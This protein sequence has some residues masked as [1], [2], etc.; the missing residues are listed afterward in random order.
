MIHNANVVYRFWGYVCLVI[1]KEPSAILTLR[2]DPHTYVWNQITPFRATQIFP[3]VHTFQPHSQHVYSETPPQCCTIPHCSTHTHDSSR[4]QA[5]GSQNTHTWIFSALWG[6]ERPPRTS[7][8]GWARVM[9]IIRAYFPAFRGS[10]TL[11]FRPVMLANESEK[12]GGRSTILP[13]GNGREDSSVFSA[14][15]RSMDGTR[16]QNGWVQWLIFDV[17]Y[18]YIYTMAVGWWKLIGIDRFFLE[19]KS[20]R[21]YFV[22]LIFFVEIRSKFSIKKT[23]N[24][25]VF[26]FSCDFNTLIDIKSKKSYAIT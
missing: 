21:F 15:L 13:S 3:I 19:D 23:V 17:I 7:I 18:I 11:V 20:V 8:N 6:H 9:H 25:T 4:I 10:L 16:Y 2:D 14:W 26:D 1:Y 5:P 12:N 24:F 22:N